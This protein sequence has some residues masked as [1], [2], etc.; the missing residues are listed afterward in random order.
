MTGI[1]GKLFGGG[2]ILLNGVRGMYVNSLAH[3]GAKG[4]ES[5][6]FRIDS[7]GKAKMYHVPLGF[8]CLRGWGNERSENWGGENG[9]K[10]SRRE[11]ERMEVPWP[12]VCR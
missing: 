6:S 8:H 9:I 2:G 12:F 1:M 7:G 10:I 4:G 5:E 3:V 11:R